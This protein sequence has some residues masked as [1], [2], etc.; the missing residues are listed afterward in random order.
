MQPKVLMRAPYSGHP[1]DWFLNI[2][3]CELDDGE[4]YVTWDENVL[5]GGFAHGHYFQTLEEAIEDF[6]KRVR[7]SFPPPEY[8]LS[9]DLADISTSYQTMRAETLRNRSKLYKDRPRYSA[10]EMLTILM[11]E[12]GKADC[13]VLRQSLPE[14]YDV[15]DNAGTRYRGRHVR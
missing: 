6:P 2:V 11:K 1:D 9:D 4:Q 12:L 10:H 15:L 8:P 14:S 13:D 7:Q 3:L 5:T